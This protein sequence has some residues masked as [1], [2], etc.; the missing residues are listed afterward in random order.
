MYICRADICRREHW[1]NAP[2]QSERDYFV[3]KC[4]FDTRCPKQLPSPQDSLSHLHEE[5]NRETL[6]CFTFCLSFASTIMVR[7]ATSPIAKYSDDQSN[8][9]EMPPPIFVINN[10]PMKIWVS[11]QVPQRSTFCDMLKV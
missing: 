3:S 4:R 5:R 10:D 8:K 6:A 7:K 11:L 2:S 9:P 1:V